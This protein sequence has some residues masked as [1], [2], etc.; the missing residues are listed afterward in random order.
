MERHQVGVFKEADE[1]RLGRLL[2]GEDRRAL[3]PERTV[4]EQF[5]RHLADEALERKLAEEQ[6]RAFL[7]LAD[8]AERDRPRAVAVRLLGPSGRG[9]MPRHF[10]R[11]LRPR[12]QQPFPRRRFD[13]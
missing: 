4:G 6:V 8:L 3:E 10:H 1:E 12:Q 9:E 13:R 2:D 5:V 11:F 7:V